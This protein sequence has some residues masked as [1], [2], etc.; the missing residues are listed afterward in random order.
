MVV[1]VLESIG[2]SNLKDLDLCMCLGGKEF[3]IPLL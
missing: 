2:G 3:G 1:L